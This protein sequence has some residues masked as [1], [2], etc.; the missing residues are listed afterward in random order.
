L[1]TGK[2]EQASDGTL[3]LDE[4]GDMSLGL[5]AK[6]LRVIQ[7]R[8]FERV[9]G[10]KRIPLRARVIAATNRDLMAEV[11]RGRFRDD[12]F[13]RLKVMTL[14]LPPLR[15]RV[16]DIP[17]LVTHLLQ[18]INEKVHRHVT[19]VPEDVLHHLTSLPWT[20]NV[21]ELENVLTRAVVLAP[22]DVLLLDNLPQLAAGGR[23]LNPDPAAAAADQPLLTLDEMERRHIARAILAH[24][25]H[26]GRICES[27][28]ISRPTL[29]RKMRKYGLHPEQRTVLQDEGPETSAV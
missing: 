25:G 6:L 8:E 7:E 4:I 18:R 12:L 3:F 1:R 27:L 13:Q 9:G 22:N 28:G 10:S 16:E 5:Q 19:R 2:C 20:G 15:E 17:V 14:V 24:R 11:T 29:E 23:S 26:K 21:R